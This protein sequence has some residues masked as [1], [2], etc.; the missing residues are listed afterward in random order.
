MVKKGDKTDMSILRK[1][2]F[3][4]NRAIESHEK[5]G[6]YEYANACR[7]LLNSYKRVIQDIYQR[8]FGVEDV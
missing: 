8:Y 2:I 7:S 4:L 1:R 6:E 3:E 5:F